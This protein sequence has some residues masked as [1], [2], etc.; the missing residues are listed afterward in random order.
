[1]LQSSNNNVRKNRSSILEQAAAECRQALS[2]D[3]SIPELHSIMASIYKEQG[4]LEEAGAE[5]REA[6]RIDPRF[7]EAYA[8]LGMVHLKAGRMV[9]AAQSFRQA[10]ALNPGNS[11]AHYGLGQVYLQKGQFD[12]AIKELNTSLYQ[13]RNSAPVH[14]ALGR[15]Y[16][17]QGNAVAAI[18]HYQEAIRIKPEQSDPYIR[19]ADLREGRGDL[20][21]AIAELRSGLE[22]MPNDPSLRLRIA[23]NNLRL[24]KLDQAIKEYRAV[25]AVAPGN[26][27]AA[28]GLTRALYLKTQKE[29]AG[30][31]M[32]SNDYES[33]DQLISQAIS[34][35]PNSMQ[36][37]LAQAKLRS[38]SGQTVDLKSL[39][40]PQNDGERL[41]YAEALLSQNKFAEAKEQFNQVI[42]HVNDSKEALAVADLALMVHDLEAAENALKKAQTFSGAEE[43]VKRGMAQ[44]A[45]IRETARQDL[46]LANDLARKKQLSSAVDKFRSAIYADPRDADARLGLAQTLEKLRPLNA[47]DLRQSLTQYQAFL[48]LA[49]DMPDKEREKLARKMQRMEA[50]A[51]KMEQQRRKIAHAPQTSARL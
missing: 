47:D 23:Q 36:L 42:S 10:I 26:T 40:T 32:A 20:E 21:H 6:L 16:D 30:A 11:S 15:A 50:R 9:D 41:A 19:I 4:Q 18:R 49:P 29:T 22:F 31:F 46:T 3:P 45:K 13:F 14:L 8:G 17:L 37:R 24:E 38:L 2:I 43:R 1:R 27:A 33:A 44:L 34:M 51:Y 7:P 5:Y 12:E 39:G 25:M 35:N 48:D 28:E